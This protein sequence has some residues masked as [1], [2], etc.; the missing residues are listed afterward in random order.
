MKISKT[1]LMA[2]AFLISLSAWAFQKETRDVDNFTKISMGVP[3]TLHL[4]I[5][6]TQS[7]VLEGDDLDEIETD[8]DNGRLKIKREGNWGWSWSDDDID[9]YI[10]IPKI[11]ALSLSGSGEIKGES[12]IKGNDLKLTVSGS[13]EVDLEIDVDNLELSISGSGEIELEGKAGEVE[14]TISGSGEVEAFDLS[15]DVLDARIS[16]SGD[17]AITVT[18]SLDARIS[19]SGEIVYSGSPD[20]VNASTSGSGRVRKK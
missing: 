14:L 16:G 9:I 20:H 11:E 13:G 15:A 4:K 18:K 1:L 19:G 8:V 17:C 5:G 2:A 10:T 7:V 6:A 3:G 12:V